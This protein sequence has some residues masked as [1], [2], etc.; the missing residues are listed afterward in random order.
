M[1]NQSPYE[2]HVDIA[3]SAASAN[4]RNMSNEQLMA[5]LDDEA[6]L[7]SIIVNLPQVRSIP[8]D[9]ESALAANKSLAEW[10]LA[11]KPRIDAAKYQTINLYEQVKRLQGEVT[12]LKNQLDSI[13]SS[14]SL[15]TTSSLMQVA[16]QEADE[17]AE[18]LFTQFENGDITIDIFLKHFKEKKT[19]AHLRKIKSDRLTALLREQTYSYAQ[20]T[21]PPPMPQP[22]YP[23]G[24]HMPG[25][26]NIPFGSGYTG[27]P[28]VSQPS[29]GRHPFF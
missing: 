4:L 14:K 21:V 17:D 20:P 22:G 19:V 7:E 1:F 9:K 28:N 10:N 11:Q 23:T 29:A 6:L 3:V 26:G 2:S 27:Y 15:D 18:S 16:A 13:S 24:N 5:L 25:L 8:T 12:V